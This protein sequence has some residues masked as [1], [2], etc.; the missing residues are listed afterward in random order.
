MSNQTKYEFSADIKQ[1]MSLIINAFYSKKDIFLRE[2]ISNSSDAIDKIRYNSLTDKLA[3]EHDD[4][5]RIRITTDKENKTLTIHDTGIG[6]SHDDLVNNLGTIAKSGTKSFFEKIK[7]TK[8]L[9]MIGQ[10]GVGF[11]S[12]YLVADKVD[13][14]TKNNDDKQ[15]LWTSDSNGSYTITEHT[16]EEVL[17]GT[18][19]IL[20]LK[21]DCHEFLEESKFKELVKSH[22]QYINYP[23]S[24]LVE[25]EEIVDEESA[26]KE[27]VVEESVVEESV[28][29]E[30]AVEDSVVEESEVEVEDVHS[31]DIDDNKEKKTKTIIKHDWE[32]LN[33]NKPLW[34]RSPDDITVSEYNE[35]YKTLSSD[36]NDSIAHKHFNVEGNV[37]F[38]S[39]LYL[40]KKAPMMQDKKI[41][42]IQLYANRVFIMDNCKDLMPEYLNFVVGIVDSSDLPLNVSREM[43]QSNHVLKLI[44]KQ[45]IKKS[46][47]LLVE[48][49]SKEEYIDFYNE[50]SKNIKLGIYED[51]SNREKLSKLLRYHTTK[52]KDKQ[53][54]FDD[55]ISRMDEKQTSIYYLSG[56]NISTLVESPLLESL[57]KKD[58]EVI[59]MIDAID[60][61]MLQQLKEYSGKKLVDI[62][63]EDIDL[64]QSEDEKETLKTLEKEYEDFNKHFKDILGNEVSKVSLTTRDIDSPCILTTSQFGWSA[65]MERIIKAQAMGNSQANSYMKGQKTL[66]INPHNRTIKALKS[67][68]LL[69]K[70]NATINDLFWL[71]YDSAKINSGYSLVNPNYF[72]KRINKIIDLGLNLDEIVQESV[73]ESVQEL[74]P[75][76]VPE[77]VL[78]SV[79]ESVQESVLESV[80]ESVPEL[81][82]ESVPDSIP[83]QGSVEELV[84][85]L[86][87]GSV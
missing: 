16:D 80:E 25:K 65:N 81:V 28:V 42:K 14:I 58:Y 34:T 75:E 73:P 59:F 84:E 1:L 76:L 85:E 40:P 55:Y 83:V 87:Q 48:L 12:S 26:V 38:T 17:R 31:D 29:E 13:V 36:W 44:K 54:S 6:M 18:K 37:E 32:V 69:E 86:V 2:L 20:H 3:L 43:I 46:I 77:S 63:K 5:L 61:Y 41:N 10:F 11:Y 30:S 45:L 62:S 49:S 33:Q 50:F 35:F 51:T 64:H 39:L 71:L 19:I 56:E 4:N 9:N 66:E 52:S 68:Y 27:S 78:E 21:D 8:D 23:I 67:K 82:P 15:L 60:E 53:T 22:S 57:N 72:T 47:N 24:L 7:D 74:V 70:N 79:Q